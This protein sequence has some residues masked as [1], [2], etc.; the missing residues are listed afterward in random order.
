M[1]NAKPFYRVLPLQEVLALAVGSSVESKSVWNVYN[2]LIN[3][4]GNEFEILFNIPREEFIRK[5]IDEKIIELVIRNRNE[6]IK[7]KPG[8]DG[9]YGKAMIGERQVTFT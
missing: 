9:E 6:K 3:H 2:S 7:V 1:N 4:F 5:N 8:F